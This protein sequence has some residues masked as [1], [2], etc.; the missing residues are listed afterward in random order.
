MSVIAI[1]PAR[2][3]S[4][5]VPNKNI[6]V[7]GDVPLLG[8]VVKAASK[9]NLID[10]I[11]FSSDSDEYFRIAKSFNDK[12]IFHKRSTELSEDV[13]SEFVLLN[14]LENF[15]EFFDD[16]SII[17]M[18][19]AT[20]P[21]I[22]TH[23]IDACI[24][25]LLKNNNANTCITVKQVSEFPEWMITQDINDNKICKMSS[26][27]SIRQNIKTRWIPNGGAYA[28]RK[29]FLEQNKLLIDKN[30][31]LIHEMS[32][33]QSL[34]IDEEEDF[35]LCKAIVKSETISPE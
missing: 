21:F 34:D 27:E 14:V 29:S 11:I 13:A 10:K 9:S 12:L 8:W 2:S 30:S 31:L 19:Q 22:S 18:L 1:I 32:K 6:R 16:N 23:N 25:K 7:L 26:E 5:S 24:S 3:G 17:V 33:I 15:K 28:V 35:E 4:K 20:T